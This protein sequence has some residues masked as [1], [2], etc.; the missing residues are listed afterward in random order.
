MIKSW[1]FANGER[2]MFPNGSHEASKMGWHSV[3]RPGSIEYEVIDDWLHTNV[4]DRAYWLGTTYVYFYR[5]SDATM[6]RLKWA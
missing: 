1:E 3:K 5:E 2:I 6:F 4:Q